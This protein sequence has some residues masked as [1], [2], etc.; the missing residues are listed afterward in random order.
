MPPNCSYYDSKCDDTSWWNYQMKIYY[1]YLAWFVCETAGSGP[2]RDC[3]RDCLQDLDEG[4]ERLL[5]DGNTPLIGYIIGCLVHMPLVVID[6]L[7]C[8]VKC[9]F[10]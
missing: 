8:F 6:H 2:W 4:R 3:V 7:I 1:C 10:K 5:G 9:L